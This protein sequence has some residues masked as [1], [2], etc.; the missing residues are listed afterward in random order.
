MANLT[1]VK[2]A[3]A[4]SAKLVKPPAP[5]FDPGKYSS[6]HTEH[7][8]LMGPWFEQVWQQEV[9]L[10]EAGLP[11][12]GIADFISRW[13]VA[14][15]RRDPV[16]LREQMTDDLVYADPT[17]GS[18]DF[19]WTQLGGTDGYHLL[20]KLFPDM[21]FYPQGLTPK[22]LPMYDFHGDTV[23]V[24]IPWRMITRMRWTPRTLDCIGVDRYYMVRDR[25]RGWLIQRID[26][27]GD[28]LFTLGQLLPI[29]IRG[30]SQA[31]LESF[32]SLLQRIRP[33]WRGPRVR[34]TIYDGV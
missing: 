14:W 8:A 23:R 29:P 3:P 4:D 5:R 34:P 6:A 33:S 31:G 12:H 17:G 28:L 1:E 27:D 21:V 10:V 2:D 9:A 13:F 19:Y 30:V 20:F 18:R 15:E 24:L 7:I 26:T 32:I 22:A 11:A 25:E 16:L